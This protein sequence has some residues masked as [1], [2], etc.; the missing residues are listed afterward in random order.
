MGSPAEIKVFDDLRAFEAGIWPQLEHKEVENSL[1]L[2]L[3]IA[4]QTRLPNVPIRFGQVLSGRQMDLAWFYTGHLVIL[5]T[6]SAGAARLMAEDFHA[7]GWDL[8]GVVGPSENAEAFAE[9][10]IELTGGS[11]EVVRQRIYECRRAIPPV[12]VPGKMRPATLEDLETLKEWA[13][14]FHLEATNTMPF[15]PEATEKN[16]RRRISEVVAFVW[17]VDGQPVSM[18]GLGRPTRNCISVGPVFTPVSHRRHGYASGL[19][20]AVTIHGHK[21]GKILAILYTDLSNPTS[22]AIYQRIGYK[23][24]C[25]SLNYW[26]RTAP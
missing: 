4:L 2:G 15:D 13:R 11:A 18:T 19:V 6:G 24:I 12:S 3:A 26:F 20:A 1:L 23:P 8:P 17:E 22:N 5:S 9:R 10:W 14:A 7:N 21:L 25:D 16:L